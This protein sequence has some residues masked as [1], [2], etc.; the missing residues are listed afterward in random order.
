MKG[1]AGSLFSSV[2]GL[3]A[4]VG[5]FTTNAVAA[6]WQ[7]TKFE[8]HGGAPYD[9]LGWRTAEYF[10]DSDDLS[11]SVVREIEDFLGDTA[12]LYES[13]GFADPIATGALDSAVTGQD[14]QPVI[15]VYVYPREGAPLGWYTS[16]PPCSQPETRRLALNVNTL[17]VMDQ[18]QLTDMA[19]QT[20]AHEL[21]HAVQRASASYKGCGFNHWISEG[22]ADAV[23]F[24]ASRKLRSIGF[25]QQLASVRSIKVYGARPY[26]DPLNT[27]D[28]QELGHGYLTSS[29]WRYL[30]EVSFKARGKQPPEGDSPAEDYHYLADLLNTPYGGRAD[31]IMDELGWFSDWVSRYPQIPGNL[32]AVYAGFVTSFADYVGAGLARLTFIPNR[33][34]WE[35]RWLG[36]VFGDCPFI[37]LVDDFTPQE[38]T[39][40]MK[41]NAANCFYMSMHPNSTQPDIKI[42]VTGTDPDTLKQLRMGMQDGSFLSAPIISARPGDHAPVYVASWTFPALRTVRMTFIVSNMAEKPTR[43]KAQDVT[44][45]VMAGSFIFTLGN[46]Q[47]GP[48]PVP[49]VYGPEQ[50]EPAP[51][52][53]P[54]RL[55]RREI[56]EQARVDIL[57]DP[58]SGIAPYASS[59]RDIDNGTCDADRLEL[60]LCGSQLNID[61]EVFAFRQQRNMLEADV[62]SSPGGLFG[63]DVA[64][65]TDP[66]FIRARAEVTEAIYALVGRKIRIFVPDIEYGFTGTFDNAV[67]EVAKANDDRHLYRAYGPGVRRGFR[68]YSQPPSGRVTIEEYGPSILRGTFE[69]DL[70][71][72]AD[73]GPDE[74]PKIA[75]TISGRFLIPSPWR[76]DPDFEIDEQAVQRALIQN[77]L[78]S[79]PFAAG[80]MR[81]MIGQ[82]GAPPP[83]VCEAGFTE[84]EIE[85]MGFTTG[86]GTGTSS[87]GS[88]AP[89]CSCECDDRETEEALPVCQQQCERDWNTCPMPVGSPNSLTS[90]DANLEAQVAEFEALLEAKNIPAFMREAN[91]RTFRSLPEPQRLEMLENYRN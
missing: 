70:I 24:Y 7:I 1:R 31:N 23:A 30:A 48:L 74:A 34:D 61:L 86:C 62:F 49:P 18:G 59:E 10:T 26:S 11:P 75:T 52:R 84:S 3:L 63:V 25:E 72:E 87:S 77:M 14:G 45:K 68:T 9:A 12:R 81:D 38:H 41:R 22:T 71:D 91:V 19:Y 79:G 40:D 57:V 20:L 33:M 47:Q 29:F 89:D 35:P 54:E 69:A 46:G 37:G 5:L 4:C 76:G 17:Q 58:I 28:P 6:P 15:R 36:R 42:E 60:N 21:F 32:P 56:V 85:A 65:M 78:Q 39:V 51:Q 13:F 53:T 8:V 2:L 50:P 55:T 82:M 73:P 80:P 64:M 44:F 16:G 43:T 67:I 66:R 27:T 90:G 88:V 83:G